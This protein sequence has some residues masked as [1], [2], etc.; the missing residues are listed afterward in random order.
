ME[1][2]KLI[3]RAKKT[4]YVRPTG[5]SY[6]TGDG[7]SFANAWS[8]F[9][10]INWSFVSKNILAVCGTH[11]QTL[12]LGANN[13]TIIGNSQYGVGIIDG[14]NTRSDGILST[15]RT[16]TIIKNISVINHT[17]QNLMLQSGSTCTTYFCTMNASANQGIQHLDT[18]SGTHFYLT[19][20]TCGDEAISVHD[21]GVANIYGGQFRNNVSAFVNISNHTCVVNIYNVWDTSGNGMDI[22]GNTGAV[23]NVY[24]SVIRNFYCPPTCTFNFY[25]S[26]VYRTPDNSA[27]GKKADNVEGTV[28]FYRCTVDGTGTSGTAQGLLDF[29]SGSTLQMQ[30]TTFINIPGVLWGVRLRAGINYE[31]INNCI[32]Y[33]VANT[34]RAFFREA[35]YTINNCIFRGLQQVDNNAGLTYNYCSITDSGTVFG[36]QTNSV[37]SNPLFTNPATLDFSTQIGSPMRGAGLT[38]SGFETGIATADWNVNPPAITTKTQGVNWDIG[39]VI[40]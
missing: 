21:Q 14:Q 5:T 33:G 22:E 11:Y 23:F 4:Y 8:G 15:S 10:A 20:N 7:T 26:Y 25:D 12:T 19:A 3:S 13:V 32:F 6:G 36:T 31:G 30:Y 16:G 9:P 1:Y 40:S 17:V 2:I 27:S 29:M 24:N 39:A 37:N 18:S 34:G 38:I 28:R 35:N